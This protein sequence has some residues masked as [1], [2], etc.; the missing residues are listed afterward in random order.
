M[1][2]NQKKDLVIL[3]A[4]T[5]MQFTVQGLLQQ[6]KKLGTRRINFSIHDI[7]VHPSKDS[8]CLRRCD[9]FLRSF[10]NEYHYS[11]VLLDLEGCGKEHLS[12]EEL[13]IDIEGRLSRS[14]WD[15]RA[16]AIVFNPEL[17]IWVWSDSPQ[18]DETL[19]WKNPEQSLR[20]WL[21]V[22]NYIQDNEVKPKRPKEAL[23]AVL[24]EIS[25]PRSSSIYHKLATAV[26]FSRCQ[27][28]AFLKFKTTLKDWFPE[29]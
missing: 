7:F 27:D 25:T 11:L 1:P 15:E 2:S 19:A 17:E 14:G 18:V 26:S 29:N 23:E 24:R 28:P 21:K 3:V 9:D 16:A 4:D 6:H 20:Q 8:G 10:T 22:K 13:E 12:R 5:N